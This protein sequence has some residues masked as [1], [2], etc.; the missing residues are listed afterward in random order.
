M[1][2]PEPFHGNKLPRKGK[3]GLI[4]RLDVRFHKCWNAAPP[5]THSAGRKVTLDRARL[6]A[7]K[8]CMAPQSAHL[9]TEQAPAFIGFDD[10]HPFSLGRTCVRRVRTS[11]CKLFLRQAYLDPKDIRHFTLRPPPATERKVQSPAPETLSGPN[12]VQWNCFKPVTEGKVFLS[13]VKQY[14]ALE[15]P[16]GSRG[17]GTQAPKILGANCSRR[18]YLYPP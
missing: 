10:T 18:F 8:V 3:T 6:G 13:P 17:Q 16:A 1:P 9:I 7:E 12:C 14:A 11:A 15:T 4:R 5:R 2:E